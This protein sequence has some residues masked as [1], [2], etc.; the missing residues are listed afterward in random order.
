MN[1]LK[2]LALAVFIIPI[3]MLSGAFYMA[4]SAAKPVLRYTTRFFDWSITE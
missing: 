1:E 3:L 4:Q 2:L